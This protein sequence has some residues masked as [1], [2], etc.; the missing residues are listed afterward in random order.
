MNGFRKHYSH[1][2]G[3]PNWCLIMLTSACSL[4]GGHGEVT[5]LF[6]AAES[7]LLDM[8]MLTLVSGVNVK[9]HFETGLSSLKKLY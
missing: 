3:V 6:I 2:E 5:S 1:V 4:M 8:Y 9:N 7:A